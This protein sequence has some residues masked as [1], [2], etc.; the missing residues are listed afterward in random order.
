MPGTLKEPPEW[1]NDEETLK[2]LLA[3]VIAALCVRLAFFLSDYAGDDRI[4]QQ[5]S[6]AVIQRFP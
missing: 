2:K 6:R 5:P 3:I 1:Y 4:V